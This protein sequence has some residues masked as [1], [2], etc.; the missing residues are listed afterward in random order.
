[1]KKS[2]KEERGQSVLEFLVSYAWMFLIIGIVA[3]VLYILGAYSP[4][5]SPH[6]RAGSCQVS[7][8]YG[9]YTTYLVTL[10]GTCDNL[11]PAYVGELSQAAGG[12]II[13]PLQSPAIASNQL[14]M[15]F[16]LTI[17]GSG[18]YPQNIVTVNGTPEAFYVYQ[19]GTRGNT[20]SPWQFIVLTINTSENVTTMSTDAYLYVN[21]TLVDAS[22]Q[23]FSPT[24]SSGVNIG[25][26]IP[27][28]GLYG[29]NGDISNLQVYDIILTPA[30]M[31]TIYLEGLGGEPAELT[32]LIAWWPLNG[33]TNDYSGNGRSSGSTSGIS[34]SGLLIQNYSIT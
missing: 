15:A 9:P 22:P 30:Q 20:T 27:P 26:A 7:R 11:N 14:T 16:W 13:I 28:Y 29:L 8:P 1:M 3:Y 4:N 34:F 18:K 19:Q 12:H 17:T 24:T 25:G 6:S 23:H 2:A 21:D 31:K 10:Q 32:N 5:L 33:D